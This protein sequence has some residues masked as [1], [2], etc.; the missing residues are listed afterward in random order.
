MTATYLALGYPYGPVVASLVVVLVIAVVTG[1]RNTAW[2]TAAGVL[3]VHATAVLLDPTREWSWAAST[4]TLAW[5]LVVL[6]LAEVVRRRERTL[7]FR[8]AVAEQRRRRAGEDRLRLA[9]ELHDV[10]TH[11]ISLIN[12]QRPWRCTFATPGRNR[13]RSRC[14][15]S[16]A[17]AR[18]PRGPPLARRRAPRGRRPRPRR[19]S[20]SLAALDDLVTLRHAGLDVTTHVHGTAEPLAPGVDLAAYAS[21]R[22]R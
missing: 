7:T 21:S 14:A 19:P 3:A 9:Q 11:H 20:A 22:R 16:R 5:T 17:P 15:S 10:V 12:V 4:A 8:R 13:S 1:H 2:L 6:A 18:G